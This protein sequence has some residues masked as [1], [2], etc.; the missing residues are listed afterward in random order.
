[1]ERIITHWTAGGHHATTVDREHYHIL[2]EGD[3]G[4]VRGDHTIADNVRTG[5]GD[6]AAHTRGKNTGSIGISL[7]C[8]AGAVQVPFRAGSFPMRP[9][10][11]DA[12]ALVAADLCEKYGIPVTPQTV[13]GHGEVQSILGA[14]QN[15]K[16]DPLV[17]P[18]DP[19][20]KARAVGD[21]FR[22]RVKTLLS[23]GEAAV[24]AVAPPP[25]TTV[26]IVVNGEELTDE[27]LL[28][29][30]GSWCPLRLLAEKLG[31][32]ILAI[33]GD[34]AT[35]RTPGRDR[36]IPSCIRGD[37]GYV[38]VRELCERMSWSAPGWDRAT[39]TVSVECPR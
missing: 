11:Y 31:W 17:L 7:C 14:P 18:W 39:R 10:Q 12:L 28:D 5:D 32:T 38:R 30:H 36:E 21:D 29:E 35:V 27:G 13:L 23:G 15:G 37:R 6:Y 8:M 19:G 3:G 4:L 16:W 9:E 25:R 26:T 33:D 22:A 1:M 24:A 2:I 34:S 20:K